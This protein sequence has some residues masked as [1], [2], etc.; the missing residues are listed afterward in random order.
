MYTASGFNPIDGLFNATGNSIRITSSP[1]QHINQG[2][3]QLDSNFIYNNTRGM[4]S[5]HRT[6]ATNV[7]LFNGTVGESKIAVSSA[8]ATQ[9]QIVLRAGSAQGLHTASMY[10]MGASMIS[11]NAAFVADYNTYINAL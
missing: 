4:K 1:F 11:E 10:A 5:I 6:S 2:A 8:R 3:T 9:N 7:Q